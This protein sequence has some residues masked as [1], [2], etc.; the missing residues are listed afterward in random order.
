[1]LGEG[2]VDVSARQPS[3]WASR[4]DRI[5]AWWGA[6]DGIVY[7]LWAAACTMY[8]A[9]AF[10]GYMRVQT[11]GVWSAPLDDVFIHFD[12]ARSF[13]RGF[14]FQWSE[15][16]GYSSGNTSLSYPIVLA[17]GYWIGFR[18]LHLMIWAAVVAVASVFGFL[19]AAGALIREV[20]PGA[21]S[22]RFARFVI[23]PAVLSMG[24]LDWTLFSG[25][26]NA[27]HLGVW[28]LSLW[29]L[30]RLLAAGSDRIRR[31]RAWWLGASGALLVATRPE[32]AVC[33]AVFGCY[34]AWRC[35]D[36]AGALSWIERASLLF[37]VGSP[38]VLL[39]LMHGLANIAF[40]G[41][42]SANGAIAKLFINDPFMSAADKWERYQS[43]LGYIVPRLTHHHFGEPKPFG[44]VVPAVALLPLLSRRLRPI[45]ILLWSQVVLW[46]LLIALNNQARWHNERYAMPAV[47]WMLVLAAFGV[48]AL[49]QRGEGWSARAW[50]LRATAAL[51]LAVGYWFVQAPRMKDQ[52]WFFARAAR[53]IYDQHV[54]AGRMLKEM[55]VKRVLVGDAGALIY[56][57]DRPGL[58]LIGLGGYHDFP[59]ARS[60]VHGLGASLELIERLPVTERPDVMAL[61]P[62]WWGDLP[63]YFGEF[64]T[65]VPVRGNVICGGAEKVLYRANWRAMD[66]RGSPRSLDS[67]ERIIDQLDVGDL[68]S[69]GVHD[70]DFPKPGMGF[71]RYRV[72]A[73]PAD[74]RRDLFDAG[75]I[76]PGGHSERAVLIAPRAGGRL[77]VRVAP[78]APLSTEVLVDGR[79]IGVLEAP[80]K[81][82]IWQ[83][84]S[85]ALP[86]GLG[87]RFELTLSAKG[88][89]SV[90]YHLWVVER[91]G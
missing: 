27:F 60:T 26:E 12:Y 65:A 58:D 72:L 45:A 7:A 63:T 8:A 42:W 19:L 74:P 82:G 83:E 85:I 73:D 76:I 31:R 80:M 25:M 22:Y 81:D 16:N 23:P 47:A 39:I 20:G 15:G 5:A 33:V 70:Y 32:S 40:T 52:I 69:E 89:E 50:P 51:A 28:G 71:I 13:A 79:A 68:L 18:Q 66:R 10:Y 75:R 91:S 43:L 88:K 36:E 55:G 61:Y 3:R 41:E 67:D 9:A 62:S 17:L 78:D 44:L 6:H 46:I 2:S 53:N 30:L 90:H 29:A 87:E 77:L 57:S 4:T 59:F 84:H 54:T 49:L 38:G 64:I 37:A 34:A 86:E 11:G 1:M 24:A 21:H 35:R 56:A 14:P 48:A